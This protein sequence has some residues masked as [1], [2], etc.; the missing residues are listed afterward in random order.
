MPNSL[1]ERLYIHSRCVDVRDRGTSVLYSAS[2]RGN[3][4]RGFCETF[5]DGI[6]WGPDGIDLGNCGLSGLD[7]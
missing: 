7:Y 2:T 4:M 3:S 5:R 1:H 6:E